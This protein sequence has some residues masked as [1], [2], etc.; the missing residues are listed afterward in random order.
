VKEESVTVDQR[1]WT[2]RMSDT[3][4]SHFRCTGCGYGASRETAPERCPMCAGVVWDYDQWRPF[5][6]RPTD[7]APKARLRA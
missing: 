7:P 2:R 6:N 3:P 5:A 1:E 4:L